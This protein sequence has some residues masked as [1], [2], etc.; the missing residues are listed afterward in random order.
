MQLAIPKHIIKEKK[1]LAAQLVHEQKR[2]NQML[3]IVFYYLVN[4]S[5]Y[6]FQIGGMKY[7]P[8]CFLARAN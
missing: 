8:I 1:W 5:C 3:E 4:K 2:N 7:L 6:H